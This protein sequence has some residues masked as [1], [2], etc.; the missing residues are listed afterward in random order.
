MT[1]ILLEQTRDKIKEL[2]LNIEHKTYS[3]WGGKEY[4][5][6]TLESLKQ[7]ERVLSQDS[8]EIDAGKE[9]LKNIWAK[10]QKIEAK[11]KCLRV[12]FL[13]WLSDKLL[14]W[15]NRVHVMSCNIDSP[16][17][18]EVAPRK[19]EESK[20][21]KESKELARMK[22]LLANERATVDKLRKEQLE[23]TTNMLNEFKDLQKENTK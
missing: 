15:S 2:E 22:E 21:A 23:M 14:S 16:C 13:D 1:N 6:K 19:K 3:A 18:I 5:Q 12:Q 8:K 4:A 9:E 10:L 7:K 17:L 11:E 20:L